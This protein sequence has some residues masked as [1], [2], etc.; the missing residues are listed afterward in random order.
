MPSAQLPPAMQE[1]SYGPR[2]RELQVRRRP[3]AA[4]GPPGVEP[5][6]KWH[7][8]SHTTG[9]RVAAIATLIWAIP[10][11]TDGPRWTE[12]DVPHGDPEKR[13]TDAAEDDHRSTTAA[14]L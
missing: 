13:R 6:G 4:V 2:D 9:D 14:P 10:G 1:F 5:A 8:A 7:L 12:T 3:V 11:D